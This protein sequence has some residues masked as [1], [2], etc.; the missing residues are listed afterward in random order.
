MAVGDVRGHR[1]SFDKLRTG[2][3][4]SIEKSETGGRARRGKTAGSGQMKDD[5][6][7]R[8]DDSKSNG[9]FVD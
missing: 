7:Q 9:Q 5:R 1:A 2:R 4:E 6:G 8:T 3:A